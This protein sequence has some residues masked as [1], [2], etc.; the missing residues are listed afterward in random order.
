MSTNTRGRAETASLKKNIEEQLNRL[1]A[2]LQDL[3]DMK[4]ELDAAE[5]EEMKVDTHQQAC[6]LLRFAKINILLL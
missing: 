5:Y 2:Q 4:G 3:E 1:L 6:I